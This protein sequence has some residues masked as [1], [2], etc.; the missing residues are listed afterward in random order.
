[1]ANNTLFISQLCERYPFTTKHMDKIDTIENLH[2]KFLIWR[3]MENLVYGE[4][5]H[6][7]YEYKLNDSIIHIYELF[8]N[9]RNNT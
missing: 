2:L 7:N 5:R 1:M 3:S 4:R 9:P 6:I 8:K